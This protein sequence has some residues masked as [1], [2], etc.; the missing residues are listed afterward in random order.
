VLD[1]TGR[2]RSA[3]AFSWSVPERRRTCSNHEAG[4][5][6][7]RN[8]SAGECILGDPERLEWSGS[9]ALC[10]SAQNAMPLS[11]LAAP[12][13][14]ICGRGELAPSPPSLALTKH[15]WTDFEP[16]RVRWVLLERAAKNIRSGFDQQ[17]QLR[18]CPSR[19]EPR[20]K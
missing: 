16:A 10:P 12:N 19:P 9:S 17:Y 11:R 5:G 14:R 1:T 6:S 4:F 7:R 8:E 20:C 15:C 13:M 18:E 2:M 3:Y